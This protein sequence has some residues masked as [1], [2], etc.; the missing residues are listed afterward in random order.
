MRARRAILAFGLGLAATPL[1]ALAQ[2]L[3]TA[4]E[5]E[6]SF[7]RI[8]AVLILCIAAAFAL[9]LLMAK[10]GRLSGFAGLGGWASGLRRQKRL[11]LVEAVHISPHAD[12]CLVTSD[13][14]EYLLVCTGGEVRI[15][16]ECPVIRDDAGP[17]S[18]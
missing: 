2:R 8:A 7:V 9:A 12:L 4:R 1:P 5:P 13:E 18:H 10:R 15:L 14:T 11:R 6:I 17:A 3:G 16:S